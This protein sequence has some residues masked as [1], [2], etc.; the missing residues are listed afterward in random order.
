M[1]S[2]RGFDDHHYGDETW[3]EGSQEY[4][5]YEG[6][7]PGEGPRPQSYIRDP[8]TP[9]RS[10]DDTQTYGDYSS[11]PDILQLNNLCANCVPPQHSN[12][13]AD[14]L[15]AD[16]SWEPVREWL[17]AHTADDVRQAAEQRG[18]SAMTAL[19]FACRNQPPSDVI[20]VLLSIAGESAHWPDAFGWLPIHY[21]CACGADAAVIKA[22]ADFNP[23]SKT[24]VDRR[25]RTPLHFALGNQNPHRMATPDVIAVLSSTGAASYEDDN[26]MLVSVS[27]PEKV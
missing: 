18:E 11:I 15:I 2:G 26:G 21:A 20:I 7:D 19:H 17:R 10:Q 1:S 3:E 16:E 8:K 22:L 14:Q 9:H 27:Y 13:E 5:N 25:G 6:H 12:T 4:D 24:T 23:D